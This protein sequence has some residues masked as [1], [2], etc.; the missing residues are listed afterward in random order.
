VPT[1]ASAALSLST[2]GSGGPWTSVTDGDVV[3]T[4]Q[5]AYHL[6]LVLNAPANQNVAPRVSALGIEFRTPV[7]VTAEATV[8]PIAQEIDVPFMAASIGEGSVSVVRTGARDFRDQASDLATSVPVSQLEVDVRLG[9]RHPRV[10]RD[11]WM[12]IDR[13]TVNNR[14]PSAGAEQSITSERDRT[15]SSFSTTTPTTRTSCPVISPSAT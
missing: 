4:K 2:A 9:S 13:A 1:G 11:A 8:T 12:L 7:D 6:K 14:A 15:S 10:T 3:T 5:Q